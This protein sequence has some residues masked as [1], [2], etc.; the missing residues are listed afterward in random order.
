MRKFELT[1]REVV[2]DDN[3]NEIKQ[4]IIR[5]CRFSPLSEDLHATYEGTEMENIMYG[6]VFHALQE[7]FNDMKE[8]YTNPEH[9]ETLNKFQWLDVKK[10]E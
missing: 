10:G 3:H 4:R 1:L 6:G 9:R 2:I 5:G 8:Y 7:L